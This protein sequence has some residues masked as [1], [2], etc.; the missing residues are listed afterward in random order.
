MKFIIQNEQKRRLKVIKRNKD[1][2]FILMK[3]PM[4]SEILGII[5]IFRQLKKKPKFYKT[6]SQNKFLTILKVDNRTLNSNNL[7]PKKNHNHI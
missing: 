7:N 5:I 6:I 1:K 3:F 4:K 2:N